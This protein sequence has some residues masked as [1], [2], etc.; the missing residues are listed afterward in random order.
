MAPVVPVV[1][2]DRLYRHYCRA[3]AV[4]FAAFT[5]YPLI[6]KL[7]EHRLH[8]DWAH[9]ALHLF[10][11]LVA[12]YAGWRASSAVA[13]RL[14]TWAIGLSYGVLGVVGWFIPG[15]LLGTPLAIPLDPVA[16]TF[17]LVLA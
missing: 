16:N 8:H 13:A 2:S 17:H 12:G 4:L 15:V 10:S 6:T 5:G 7:I 3:A 14:F 11:C 1:R 9:S